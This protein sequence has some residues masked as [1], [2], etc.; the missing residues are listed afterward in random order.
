MKKI[1]VTHDLNIVCQNN[2]ELIQKK[3]KDVLSFDEIVFLSFFNGA[4]SL[5]N[6]LESKWFDIDSQKIGRAVPNGQFEIV[7]VD[8][9]LVAL[10]KDKSFLRANNKDTIDLVANKRNLWETFKLID[11]ED[12]SRIAVFMKNKWC[13]DFDNSASDVD[14]SKS[15]FQEIHI[16]NII[17]PFDLLMM[18]LKASPSM[19]EIV[20]NV[21]WKIFRLSRINPAIIYVIFGRGDLLKQAK[22]SIESLDKLGKF[23]GDL[24]FITNLPDSEIFSLLPER[25]LNK[26]YIIHYDAKD[27][28]D[29]VG[30]RLSI[31]STNLLEQYQPI[32]YSDADI[33]YDR[34]IE[35]FIC[36]SSRSKKCSAQIEYFHKFKT[37]SHTGATLF[38]KDPFFIEDV[39]GFNGGILMVPNI[40]SHGVYLKHAY[41]ALCK[42]TDENGR[43]SLPFYDQSILNYILYKMDDFD[44]RLVTERTQIGGEGDKKIRDLYDLDPKKTKGFVHFWNSAKRHVDMEKYYRDV[45][46]NS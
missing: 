45:L 29:F 40:D 12:F 21:N 8:N 2:G 34:N 31:F 24:F 19:N 37:S 17:I 7:T 43:D 41:Y 9:G 38:K 23:L 10:K 20:L 30:A 18:Y 1:I 28:L 36:K 25:F 6:F 26:S 22:I 42:Y 46:Q 33:V 35:E 3:I 14:Y 27:R 11:V 16:N 4:L 44:G 13:V 15:N 5:C 32:I 39:Y